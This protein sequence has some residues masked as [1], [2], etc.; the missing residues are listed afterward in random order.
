MILLTPLLCS[1]YNTT[2]EV[3]SSSSYL[4]YLYSFQNNIFSAFSVFQ[5]FTILLLKLSIRS[6]VKSA[7]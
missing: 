5:G 3:L 7:G 1:H 6:R 4:A 2:T